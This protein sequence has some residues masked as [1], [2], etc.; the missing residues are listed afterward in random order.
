MWYYLYLCLADRSSVSGLVPW[1]EQ[2]PCTTV[3]WHQGRHWASG[4]ETAKAKRC[5]LISS[6]YYQPVQAFAHA[7]P[8][9]GIYNINTFVLHYG[10]GKHT[11]NL[12]S[13]DYL[14]PHIQSDCC[15]EAS[16]ENSVSRMS[17]RMPQGKGPLSEGQIYAMG[18]SYSEKTGQKTNSGNCTFILHNSFD[19]TQIF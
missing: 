16:S 4:S 8:W 5:P 7:K 18:I 17:H 15:P 10:K 3:A 11:C 19:L 9:H 1:K 12:S 2:L 6:Q 14:S 13:S